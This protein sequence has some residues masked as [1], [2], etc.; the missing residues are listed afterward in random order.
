VKAF[1]ADSTAIR[2]ELKKHE[3]IIAQDAAQTEA[4][5]SCGQWSELG[6][7]EGPELY[8]LWVEH[9][10]KELQGPVLR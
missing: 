7:A 3:P 2:V 6:T 4:R 10:M 9:F 8:D 1:Y 5:C